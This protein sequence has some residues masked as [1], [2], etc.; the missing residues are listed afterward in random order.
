MNVIETNGLTKYYGKSRGIIDL[1]LSVVEGD[2]FGFIGPN[3]SGKSTTIRS[4]LG[5]ITPTSGSGLIF[6]MDCVRNKLEILS[7]VGY[8]PSE[9]MFYSGMRVDEI[10]ALS[11]KLHKK[12]CTI[13]AKELCERFSVDT[14]KKVDELSLGNRRKVSI[15]CAMQHEPRLYILDEATSGLDPLMQNEFFSLLNECNK[16]GATIFMSSHVLSEI[17]RY[18]RHAGVVREGKLITVSTV[19]EITKSRAKRVVLHGIQIAPKLSGIYDAST[20]DDHISFLYSGEMHSLIASL[21]GF[22]I[23][24]MTV[25]EPDLDE[26]F[27]HFYG[28]ESK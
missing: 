4:L 10:I 15:V 18:C 7:D 9:A 27:M 26:I 5:L 14:K 25:S 28:G 1:S 2:F 19:E 21:V 17:Q 23:T 8:V 20:Y 13:K 16:A 6:G 3:G 11:A 24:D 22:P 12:D